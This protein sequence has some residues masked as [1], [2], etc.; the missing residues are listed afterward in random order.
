MCVPINTREDPTRMARA[1]N[2]P[3]Q[4]TEWTHVWVWPPAAPVLVLIC[5]V[6]L[7]YGESS[8]AASTLQ[9]RHGP[10]LKGNRAKNTKLAWWSM[11]IMCKFFDLSTG[12]SCLFYQYCYFFFL[13]KKILC[14]CAASSF[15]KFS[16]P[17]NSNSK[18]LFDKDCSLSWAVKNV[19]KN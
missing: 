19:S 8:A 2:A 18:T 14:V 9:T 17:Q 7:S 12:F 15:R 11:K 5:Y 13:N 4:T 16:L 1:Y 10:F 6:H 3:G